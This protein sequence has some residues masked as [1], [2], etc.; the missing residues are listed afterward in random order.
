MGVDERKQMVREV[1]QD[2]YSEGFIVV[3]ASVLDTIN[4]TQYENS[5][6]Q[7]TTLTPYQ[8][9]NKR[10]IP[11]VTSI[12]TVKKMTVDGRI[13]A[14]EFYYEGGKMKILTSAIKRM[15]RG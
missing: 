6:L 10:L 5:M 7:H 1:I 8:I 3:P 15:R 2:L 9:A 13:G 14:K 11:G 4:T 12:G